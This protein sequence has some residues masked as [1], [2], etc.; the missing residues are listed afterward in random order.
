MC[1]ESALVRGRRLSYVVLIKTINKVGGQLTAGWSSNAFFEKFLVLSVHGKSERFG[2]F[3]SY[4]QEWIMDT[5][6][7]FRAG[8]PTLTP[9]CHQ[10]VA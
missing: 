5:H 2:G 1:H 7:D 9:G 4:K 6:L 8:D 3:M 10:W